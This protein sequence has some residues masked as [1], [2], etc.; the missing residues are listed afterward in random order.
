MSRAFWPT[1]KKIYKHLKINNMTQETAKECS[2]QLLML[3]LS[4]DS[5]MRQLIDSDGDLTECDLGAI[6]ALRYVKSLIR[7]RD[8]Q[9][10]MI[11]QTQIDTTDIYINNHDK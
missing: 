3:E 7:D 6:N 9:L 11:M 8:A 5:R 4:V 1:N 10:K 2:T